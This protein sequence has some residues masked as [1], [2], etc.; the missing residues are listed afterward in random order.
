MPERQITILFATYNGADTLPVMMEGLTRVRFPDGAWNI[1]AVDNNSRDATAAI[2]SRYADRL[3][4]TVLSERRQGKSC[5]LN[6]GI[7]HVDG[8]LVVVTDDDIIPDASWLERLWEGAERH[9]D[10]DVFSGTIRPA[11]PHQPPRWLTEWVALGSTFALNEGMPEGPIPSGKVWGP[12]SA[13]RCKVFERG[14]R[15][16]EGIGP[17]G[18]G[19]YP[20]G[21]DTVFARLVCAAGF[22]AYHLPDAV[23]QHIIPAEFMNE[24]WI[25]RRAERLGL[26][27]PQVGPERIAGGPRLRNVPVVTLAR[28]ALWTALRPVVERMPASKF[29]FWA[30]W[31][32]YYLRGLITALMRQQTDALRS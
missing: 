31:R 19:P 1:I 23:V 22:K 9:P 17:K 15:F 12:N 25:L 6:T 18:R 28:Y 10:Y 8:R 24:A 27:V 4:L 2:L 20:M 30:I 7:G 13:F 11:W 5:A 14:L 32:C 16:P 3:P 29:R 26:G 21:N